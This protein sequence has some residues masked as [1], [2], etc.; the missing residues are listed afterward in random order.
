M[1]YNTVMIHR[2]RNQS[3]SCADSFF[4]IGCLLFE[5]CVILFCHFNKILGLGRDKCILFIENQQ[6]NAERRMIHRKNASGSGAEPA[7]R[8][9]RPKPSLTELTAVVL[10]V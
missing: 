5:T 9:V 3:I 10:V 4:S 2:K 6:R 7:R 8:N 1:L